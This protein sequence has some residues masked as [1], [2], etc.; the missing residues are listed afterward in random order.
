MKSVKIFSAFVF[1]A[2]FSVLLSIV[3]GWNL[4]AV[5]ALLTLVYC[6]PMPAGVAG[7]NL[8]AINRLASNGHLT[9][10]EGDMRNNDYT[11][12]GDHLVDFGGAK[13]DFGTELGSNRI[14]AITIVNA[15]ASSATVLLNPS[16]S[17][18]TGARVATAAEGQ[19]IATDGTGTVSG[20]GSPS[21]I[22]NFLAFVKANPTRVL[23]IKI[24]ST[25]D[26]QLAVT[27]T[28]SRKSPFRNLESELIPLSLYTSEYANNSKMITVRREFQLD[29]QTEV[30]VPV[31]AGTTTTF[32]L[33]CGAVLNTSAALNTKA[34]LASTNPQVQ[35]VKAAISGQ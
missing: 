2:L 16:Y 10:Y 12:Y 27:M 15:S 28:I 24:S 30:A 34:Q 22:T 18:Q 32:I 29:D 3:F 17:P 35:S 1:I 11:G 4:F 6:I 20:S 23:G 19:M 13:L 31:P 25:N 9:N 21:T 14:F 5:S 7:L 26:A 8:P 33:V